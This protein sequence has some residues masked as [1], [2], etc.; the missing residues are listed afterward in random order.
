M[1]TLISPARSNEG[2]P[3]EYVHTNTNSNINLVG[4]A[5]A[6]GGTQSNSFLY[7]DSFGHITEYA[8]SDAGK[9]KLETG[10]I[11]VGNGTNEKNTL[12]ALW[13][14]KNTEYAFGQGY[15]YVRTF[16]VN[17]N[18]GTGSSIAYI[19]ATEYDNTYTHFFYNYDGNLKG[20]HRLYNEITTR[21]F[22]YHIAIV[23]FFNVF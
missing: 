13:V 17:L 20:T 21:I 3:L 10:S 23:F 1:E 5:I 18:S 7:I 12:S 11:F 6:T 19:Y 9:K 16:Q 2:H 8:L 22:V 4:Y 14:E 15:F